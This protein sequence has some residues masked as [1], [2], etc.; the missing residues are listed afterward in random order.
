[1]SGKR[2]AVKLQQRT[3]AA[4][5]KNVQGAIIPCLHAPIGAL[6]IWRVYSYASCIL[7]K[8]NSSYPNLLSPLR[9]NLGG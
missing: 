9:D 6:V 8:L 4:H 5:S 3:D 2:S 7:C 1:M